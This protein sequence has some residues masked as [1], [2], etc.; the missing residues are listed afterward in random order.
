[1]ERRGLIERVLRVYRKGLQ[2]YHDAFTGPGERRQDGPSAAAVLPIIARYTGLTV[3]Q[4]RSGI[5]YLDPEARLDVKDVLH[6]IDWYRS[7]GLV[8]GAVD[9]D[10]LIDRRYVVP[11]PER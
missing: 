1:D 9:G 5:V 8:K 10:A 4:A 7:Q 3:E 2:D 6:Q 11:L